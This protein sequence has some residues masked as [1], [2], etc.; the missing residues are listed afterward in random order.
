MSLPLP[1]TLSRDGD[2]TTA[3]TDFFKALEAY[4]QI[5]RA[6]SS[7]VYNFGQGIEPQTPEGRIKEIM[8][9]PRAGA[10][11]GVYAIS[12]GT[13]DQRTIAASWVTRFYNIPCTWENT[14][15]YPTHGRSHIERIF[16]NTHFAQQKLD[17]TQQ[18]IVILEDNHWPMLTSQALGTDLQLN[19]Y[20]SYNPDHGLELFREN[21]KDKTRC[22][23]FYDANV[24]NPLSIH[25]NNAWYS[26]LFATADG[27]NALRTGLPHSPILID[28]PY[29]MARE[30]RNLKD[31]SYFDA[32]FDDCLK[33]PHIT[34]YYIDI[35]FSKMIGDATNGFSIVVTHPKYTEAYRLGNHRGQMSASNTAHVGRYMELMQRDNDHLLLSHCKDLREKY[36]ANGETLTRTIEEINHPDIRVMAGGIGMTKAVQ[37]DPSLFQGQ[38]VKSDR[39]DGHAYTLHDMHDFVN[40]IGQEYGVICVKQAN[41]KGRFALAAK[42][43]KF[44]AGM[45]PLKQ[46]IQKLTLTHA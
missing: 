19:E 33:V 25:K 10:L 20:D 7:G 38:E 34:P 5:H 3:A 35:S 39:F 43:D 40:M 36:K 17:R 16:L 12:G 24:T 22:S 28:M 26:A 21:S 15:I 23:L 14:L 11:N 37:F 18:G 2:P 29:S 41:D 13:P 1:P 31:V 45:E 32:G 8:T 46:G 6:Y 9:E 30:Q 44:S 42:T 27:V 4:N